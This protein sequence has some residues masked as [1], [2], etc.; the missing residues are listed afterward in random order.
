[1]KPK[2]FLATYFD[3]EKDALVYVIKK[4]TKRHKFEVLKNEKG[5]FVV[6]HSVLKKVF[7]WA[8][9]ASTTGKGVAPKRLPRQK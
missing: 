3:N 5:F 4:S 1:M 6:S 7:G 8:P 2:L 9:A